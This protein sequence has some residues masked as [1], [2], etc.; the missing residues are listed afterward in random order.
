MATGCGVAEVGLAAKAGEHR[1]DDPVV[2]GGR[3]G[4]VEVERGAGHEAGPCLS[5][6]MR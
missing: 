6:W 4:V 2:N 3:G 5:R 1:F